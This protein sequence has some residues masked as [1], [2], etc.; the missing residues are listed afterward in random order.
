MPIPS[1][2]PPRAPRVRAGS[3]PRPRLSSRHGRGAP[4][5]TASLRPTRRRLMP[6]LA[7]PTTASRPTI[8]TVDHGDVSV[9]TGVA[10]VRGGPPTPG[11]PG[12]PPPG[13]PPPGT[14]PPGA[15]EPAA[16]PPGPGEAGDVTSGADGVVVAGVLRSHVG[17]VNVSFISVTAP[18]RA[19][20]RPCTVTELFTVIDVKARML[21]AKSEPEP[22]VAELPTFQ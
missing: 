6:T 19:R 15:P 7:I 5:A 3:P 14:P 8:S 16:P 2:P 1:R 18:L 13:T 12:M 11:M 20:A 10:S 21:P 22:S 17:V 9:P 4:S